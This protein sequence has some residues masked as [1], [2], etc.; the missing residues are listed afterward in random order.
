[1]SAKVSGIT[2]KL[3][4]NGKWRQLI[5]SDASL[6]ASYQP[7]ATVANTSKLT[8]TEKKVIL[9]SVWGFEAH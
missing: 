5:V 2:S 8:S 1:M 3:G 4:R 7:S 6:K 9:I